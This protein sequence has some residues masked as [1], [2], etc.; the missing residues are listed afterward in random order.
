[1]GE[2]TRL[3][4]CHPTARARPTTKSS[5]S[6]SGNRLLTRCSARIIWV[7]RGLL[8]E[9][10]E[11]HTP[12]LNRTF[13]NAHVYVTITYNNDLWL[14]LM[15]FGPVSIYPVYPSPTRGAQAW[16]LIRPALTPTA[17]DCEMVVR[18]PPDRRGGPL[19]PFSNAEGNVIPKRIHGNIIAI[20]ELA[21][22]RK[23]SAST[24]YNLC[25]EGKIPGRKV[26]RHWRFRKVVIDRRLG[27]R[28]V[29]A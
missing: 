23:F 29:K 1:M 17:N 20:G 2:S 3:G 25:A 24:L 27:Y 11:H 28:T 4:H 12:Y 14:K 10:R 26:G 9:S 21:K 16:P 19:A 7:S 5:D 18:R 15:A 22:Y 6:N 13:A 8:L